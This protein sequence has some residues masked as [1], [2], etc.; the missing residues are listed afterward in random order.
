[1]LGATT[2]ARL[3]KHV[4]DTVV[5]TYGTGDQAPAYVPPTRL[6]IVGTATFPAVGFSTFVAD[7]TSMGTGALVSFDIEPLAFRQAQ[8][9]S[10]PNL[11]AAPI[12]YS[13]ACV[14]ASARRKDALTC[15]A[16]RA[17]PTRC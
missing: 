2:L 17:P 10:D 4:G 15:S 11:N 16:S 7:H 6:H 3:H 5:V 14:T 13:C 8:I 1:V 9:Q 12:S